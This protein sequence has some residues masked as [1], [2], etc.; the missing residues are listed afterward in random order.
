M[1]TQLSQIYETLHTLIGPLIPFLVP[2]NFYINLRFLCH[3]KWKTSTASK[4]VNAANM[5]QL[6]SRSVPRV[7]L[8][9]RSMNGD[10]VG[11]WRVWTETVLIVLALLIWGSEWDIDE[12]SIDE[13][14]DE[15][16]ATSDN[17]NEQRRIEDQGERE[18][19]K[20]EIAVECQ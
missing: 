11:Q 12:G 20:G 16:W 6:L 3:E 8:I 5:I 18:Y 9:L 19:D 4:F 7:L 14:L 13:M 1:A 15:W 17:G 2:I 10:F